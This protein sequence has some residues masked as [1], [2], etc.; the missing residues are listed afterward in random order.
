MKKTT[1]K[2]ALKALEKVA[3]IESIPVPAWD[4]PPLC[5]TI[6]HQPKRFKKTDANK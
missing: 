4:W 3:R 2:K 6:L 1:E 5:G